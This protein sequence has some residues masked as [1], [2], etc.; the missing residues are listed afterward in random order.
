MAQLVRRRLFL[1][2]IDEAV[3]RVYD[4]I[5]G[6]G[7]DSRNPRQI[8]GMI[9]KKIFRKRI[10]GALLHETGRSEITHFGQ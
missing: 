5:E 1:G 8:V 6:R 7:M 4:A 3:D 2:A 10:D 9:D